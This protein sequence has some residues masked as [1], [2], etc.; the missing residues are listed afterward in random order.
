[1]HGRPEITY[2]R[3]KLTKYKTS[4]LPPRNSTIYI[5]ST[6]IVWERSWSVCRS[7]GNER[8]HFLFVL[9]NTKQSKLGHKAKKISYV[10][11]NYFTT[12]HRALFARR[13]DELFCEY[14]VSSAFKITKCTILTQ[15]LYTNVHWH[16]SHHHLHVFLGVFFFTSFSWVPCWHNFQQK[17]KKYD[18]FTPIPIFWFFW[19]V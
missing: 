8:Y 1:M 2:S 10:W 6:T 14:K 13:T 9:H 19:K 15:L 3:R 4:G 5:H 16:R 12:H 18:F 7:A 17:D 11:K